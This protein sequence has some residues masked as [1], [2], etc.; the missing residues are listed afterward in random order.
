M[1][2]PR[3]DLSSRPMQTSKKVLLCREGRAVHR[4]GK[5]PARY[6]SLP[7]LRYI[8]RRREGK[9]GGMKPRAPLWWIRDPDTRADLLYDL[10][11]EERMNAELEDP[12]EGPQPW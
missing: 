8:A 9:G 6:A 10:A 11:R 4:D 12:S 5:H 3:R 1:Q 7:A 2:L